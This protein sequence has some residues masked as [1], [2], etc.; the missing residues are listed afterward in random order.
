MPDEPRMQ[1][2][3]EHVWGPPPDRSSI[4]LGTEPGGEVGKE[5]PP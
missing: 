2:E 4:L 1:N 5:A 3:A